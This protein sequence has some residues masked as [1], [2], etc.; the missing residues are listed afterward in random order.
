MNLEQYLSQRLLHRR[1]H[2]CSINCGDAEL[3]RTQYVG[4]TFIYS[5]V[6]GSGDTDNASFSSRAT[7][8]RTAAVFDF[9]TKASYSVRLRTTDAGG[10]KHDRSF[11][12]SVN[13]VNE[14]PIF[15]LTRIPHLLQ[16]LRLQARPLQ[17]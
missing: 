3:D 11:T 5:L 4:D 17:R 6:S 15:N 9:E 7:R 10:L 13:N 1:G 12:I 16:S 8:L 14:S 2:G